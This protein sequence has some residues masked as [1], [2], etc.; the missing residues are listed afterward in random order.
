[1]KPLTAREF[2]RIAAPATQP[3]VL[4]GLKKIF[5]EANTISISL[6]SRSAMQIEFR[7]QA[8]CLHAASY[9]STC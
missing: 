7:E 9:A 5:E 2:D 6:G 1:M 3:K 8:I 4:W